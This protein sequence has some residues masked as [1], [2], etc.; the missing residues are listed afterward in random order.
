MVQA[1]FVVDPFFPTCLQNPEAPLPYVY[2]KL[3]WHAI[4]WIVSVGAVFALC[5]SLLGAMFPLPRILYAMS[6]DGLLYS[7]FNRVNERSKTPVIA[8][9]IS[10]FIA[11]LMALIFDLVSIYKIWRLR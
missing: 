7:L 2:D 10:G 4:K 9:I 3:G 6:S 11:A 1:L 8:T 5:T